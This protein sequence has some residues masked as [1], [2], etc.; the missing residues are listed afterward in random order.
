MARFHK[1]AI[2]LASRRALAKAHG[3]QPLTAI[4]AK[5]HYCGAPGR[6]HWITPSWVWFEALEMDHVHPESL[7]GTSEPQNLVL[8][9]RRCNRSKGA[10]H[11]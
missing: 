4:D 6:I 11:A 10:R 5:C 8:A 7:G 2:P 1:R 3:C 9:C